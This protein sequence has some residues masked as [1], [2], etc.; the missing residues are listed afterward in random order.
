M[1]ILDPL[2]PRLA[3]EIP[4][5]LGETAVLPSLSLNLTEDDGIPRVSA[6]LRLAGTKSYAWHTAAV[7]VDDIPKIIRMYQADPEALL[8]QLYK[9]ESGAKAEP[10]PALLAPV[11]LKKLMDLL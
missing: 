4:M 7:P 10:E 8:L 2:R 5:L 3:N 11:E 1:Q 9:W 6:M